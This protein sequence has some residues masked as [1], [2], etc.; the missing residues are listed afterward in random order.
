[1]RPMSRRRARSLPSEQAERTSMPEDAF[2]YIVVGSGAGGGTVA[3]RLAE[4]GY[5]VLVLEAGGDPCKLEGGNALRD[6]NCLPADYEVPASHAC[7]TENRAMAG[8]YFVRHSA[9]DDQQ[10]RDPKD[11]FEE[12]RV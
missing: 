10:Q 9:D 8:D 12:K 3:A 4:F 7:S 5:R 2:D 1:M 6:E 11:R